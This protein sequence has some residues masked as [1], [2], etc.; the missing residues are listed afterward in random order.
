MIGFSA[1]DTSPL[2][3]PG[4]SGTT[5]PTG[6]TTT[7][8]LPTVD[9]GD[10][11]LTSGLIPFTA[12]EELLVYLRAE[13]A[14]RVDRLADRHTVRLHRPLV[15]AERGHQH[16]ER[17]A[18]QVKVRDQP[19]H[20][21]KSVRGPDEQIRHTAAPHHH[22][23]TGRTLERAHH[24][25]AHR[26]DAPPLA[27]RG[28]DRSGRVGGNEVPLGVHVVLRRI[29]GF[30]GAERAHTHVQGDR[31]A[32]HPFRVDFGQQLASEVQSGRGRG[33]RARYTGV[34]GL[35]ALP[36]QGLVVPL[37]IGRQRHV[38]VPFQGLPHR[39]LDHEPH[40]PAAPRRPIHDLH[41]EA[42]RY[43]H[44][45]PGF[46]LSARPHQRF[47]ESRLVTAQATR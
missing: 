27:E 47:P 29:I 13:A 12:C 5:P 32:L 21:L 43:V 7:T 42:G 20:H 31:H 11:Q 18:W 16:Q 35:V 41:V 30:H 34:H 26:P 28:V 9:I 23:I 4:L 19:V 40:D 15:P 44:H 45:S 10:V 8:T 39:T 1:G 36:V 14:E 24:G 6:L 17:G 38:A 25:R 22:P 3:G 46:E 37:E 33:H 2:D